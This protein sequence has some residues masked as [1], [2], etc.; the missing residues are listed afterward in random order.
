MSQEPSFFR[1]KLMV[2]IAIA[3]TLALG[4]AAP[5]SAAELT[6]SNG[7]F[8]F[9]DILKFL[10]KLGGTHISDADKAKIAELKEQQQVL[11]G[12]VFALKPIVMQYKQSLK[13]L[14]AQL[15]GIDPENLEEQKEELA[16]QIEAL[17]AKIEKL[18]KD[19][20]NLQASVA[21]LTAQRDEAAQAAES[22]ENQLEILPGNPHIEAAV[23]QLYKAAESIQKAIESLNGDAS[24]IEQEKAGAEIELEEKSTFLERLKGAKSL[25]NQIELHKAALADA[26]GK[27]DA[28]NAEL[29]Q[30]SAELAELSKGQKI[31]GYTLVF[32]GKLVECKGTTLKSCFEGDWKETPILEDKKPNKDAAKPEDD[33][34][35]NGQGKDKD[36]DKDKP[37][38]DKEKPGK[39]NDNPGQGQDNPGKGEGKPGKGEGKPGKESDVIEPDA[40][41][42]A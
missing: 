11:K 27:L 25:L 1:R 20:K 29:A 28:K 5:A 9:Q 19:A 39:G 26:Q 16:T 14:Q 30:V 22:L 18:T 34:P 3:S 7:S 35:G 31:K 37:G 12:E 13:Q 41:T 17:E 23:Q 10:P 36:K 24:A 4:A 15:D 33:E 8:S 2:P 21:T 6:I 38:K 42:K 32:N 40:E